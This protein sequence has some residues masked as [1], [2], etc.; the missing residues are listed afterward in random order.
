MYF[1]FGT[2]GKKDQFTVY[3]AYAI[4]KNNDKLDSS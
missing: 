1:D 2:M 3:S 4:T